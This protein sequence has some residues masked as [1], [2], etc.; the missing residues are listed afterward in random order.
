MRHVTTRL[1]ILLML[2]IMVITGIYG[3]RRLTR[4][5]ER[6]VEQSRQD[7]RIFAETLAL[8]VRQNIRRGRTTDELRELI[9]NILTSPGLAGV[10]IYDPDGKVVAEKVAMG[11]AP[12]VLDE[13][14]KR[15][16]IAGRPSEVL[17]R[18]S[19]GSLLRY[20]QPLR[21]PGGRTGALE[22]RHSL[23]DMERKYRA[24]IR[25]NI[26]SR[27]AFLAFFVASVTAITRWSITRPIRAL[28]AGAQAVGRG[29]L[30][31]SITLKRRDEF[32]QLAEEFNRMAANLAEAHQQL[33]RQGEERL[34]LEGEVQQGQK[35][36]AVGLLAAEVAHEIGTPLNIISG[37]AEILGRTVGPDHA[38]R[39]HLNAI[40]QQTERI[41]QIIRALLEYTRPRHPVLAPVAVVPI[42]GQVADLLLDRSRRRGVR[43]AL[44][45]PVWLPRVLA[46]AD[47]L[48]RLFLNL[49]LNALDVSPQGGAVRVSVGPD[50]LLSSEGRSAIVRGEAG[51]ASLAVH[52]VDSGK[53][54]TADQLG[55]VFE[56]FF[57]TKAQ[58]QGTGLGLP[59]AEQIVRGHRGEIEMLSIPGKGTEVIVRLLLASPEAAAEVP[60]APGEPGRGSRADAEREH[61]GPTERG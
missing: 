53:G 55:H 39:R 11:A 28:I 43:I 41:S 33:L 37:R 47:Q 14:V 29:D 16:L 57:S 48:Q 38:E 15:T 2:C 27:L 5:R 25:E 36:A 21:W 19:S 49:L 59:I 6:L 7:Q 40:L 61:D 45:V 50:P 32:G 60:A 18:D 46:D 54:L 35:L 4:D 44:D 12:L 17:I 58:G 51:G 56:P 22:V 8:A 26:L 30:T 20:I 24:A 31:Q 42:L 52:V 1:V 34:R 23:A 9:D 13:T 3:Y 10:F